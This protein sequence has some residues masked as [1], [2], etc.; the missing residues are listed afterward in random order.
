[1]CGSW[2]WAY[3]VSQRAENQLS[4]N[5]HDGWRT[6]GRTNPWSPHDSI[7]TTCLPLQLRLQSMCACMRSQLSVRLPA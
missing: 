3:A 1:M 7:L 4:V 2:G 5:G 6:L